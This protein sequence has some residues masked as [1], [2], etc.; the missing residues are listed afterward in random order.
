MRPRVPNASY[1]LGLFAVW[2]FVGVKRCWVA[3]RKWL[4]KMCLGLGGIGKR[5]MGLSV[6]DHGNS[7]FNILEYL[8]ITQRLIRYRRK[9]RSCMLFPFRDFVRFHYTLFIIK[10]SQPTEPIHVFRPK[11]HSTK[12]EKKPPQ[13]TESRLLAIKKTKHRGKEAPNGSP[14]IQS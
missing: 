7:E 6:A 1:H 11:S 14:T 2:S 13:T 12:A 8:H 10:R 4:M 9:F 5:E 3:I